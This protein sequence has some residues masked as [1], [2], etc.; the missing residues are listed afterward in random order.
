MQAPFITAHELNQ[1]M[2]LSAVP[3]WTIVHTIQKQSVA[4]H[5]FNV[6]VIALCLLDSGVLPGLDASRLVRDALTHDADESVTGDTPSTAKTPKDLEDD[7]QRAVKIA[8]VLEALTFI[9]REVQMGN[10]TVENVHDQLEQRLVSLVR[11]APGHWPKDAQYMW[12]VCAKVTNRTQARYHPGMQGMLD[13][14]GAYN[15]E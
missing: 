15:G 7:Y 9:T 3:R 8:D 1:C 2:R 10:R 13:D 14:T 11:S 4:E 5:S 12:E 6:A